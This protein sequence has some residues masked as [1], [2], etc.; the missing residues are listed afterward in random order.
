MS[1]F[2]TVFTSESSHFSL[3][4][5]IFSSSCWGDARLR[6][7]ESDRDEIWQECSSRLT[8]RLIDWISDMRS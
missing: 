1:P 2:I 7:F 5:L 4:L 6:R 8:S 3:Y